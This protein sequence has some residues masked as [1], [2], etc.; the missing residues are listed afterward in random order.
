MEIRDFI[1][2]NKDLQNWKDFLMEHPKEELAEL[3]L[4]R[5]ARDACFCR[6]IYHK[7]VQQG[8]NKDEIVQCYVI[9]IDNEMNK[10]VPDVNFLS[11]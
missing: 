8:T 6:E 2:T 7:L 4:D 10:R 9:A 11:F 5:M 3:I 1:D